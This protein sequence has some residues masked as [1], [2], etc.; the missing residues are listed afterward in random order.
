MDGKPPGE[1]YFA[2]LREHAPASLR[3]V[4]KGNVCFNVRALTPETIADLY[5]MFKSGVACYEERGLM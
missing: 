3:K 2:G 1:Q 5:A 4:L